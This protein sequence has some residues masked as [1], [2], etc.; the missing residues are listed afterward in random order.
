[1]YGIHVEDLKEADDIIKKYCFKNY[2]NLIEIREFI[3]KLKNSESLSR[4]RA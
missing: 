1:M 4:N 2:K 3:E